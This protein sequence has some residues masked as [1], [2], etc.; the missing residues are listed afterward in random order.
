VKSWLVSLA[1]AVLLLF[2]DIALSAADADE[3]GSERLTGL[4]SA[5]VGANLQALCDDFALATSDA[6]RLDSDGAWAK[7][8][9]KACRLALTS[10]D[11]KSTSL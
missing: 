9:R 11:A 8:S 2:A 3:L 10:A 1:E 7:S 5:N 4:A 6:S